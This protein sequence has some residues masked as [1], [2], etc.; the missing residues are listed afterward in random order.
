MAAACVELPRIAVLHWTRSN[1]GPWTHRQIKRHIPQS[2]FVNEVDCERAFEIGFD[3]DWGLSMGTGFEAKT[4]G[5]RCEHE[6]D[7]RSSCQA[8]SFV[9]QKQ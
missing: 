4:D 1:V 3:I 5:Q 9:L 8:C 2:E 7:E 6:Y